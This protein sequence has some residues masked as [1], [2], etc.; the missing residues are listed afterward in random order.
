MG[1][2]NSGNWTKS[3]SLTDRTHRPREPSAG[4][5]ESELESESGLDFELDLSFRFVSFRNDFEIIQ[6]NGHKMVY[7]QVEGW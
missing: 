3:V 5:P 2:T 6:K 7:F 1:K 4:E